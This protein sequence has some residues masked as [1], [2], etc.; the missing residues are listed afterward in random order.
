MGRPIA[1]TEPKAT[2][3]TTIAA[4]RPTASVLGSPLVS[5]QSPENW[6]LSPCWRNG[7]ASSRMRPAVVPGLAPGPSARVMRRD[8]DLATRR[9]LQ[10]VDLGHAGT[11]ATASR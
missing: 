1:T 2:S 11:L 4:R 5:N 10:R 6:T 9:D 7:A 3:S 8:G